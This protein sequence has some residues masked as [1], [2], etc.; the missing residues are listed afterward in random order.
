MNLRSLLLVVPA[1]SSAL[2]FADAPPITPLAAKSWLLLDH[3]SGQVLTAHDAETRIEPASLTKLMTAY[4]T[5]KSLKEGKI[6]LD[7][8]FTVSMKGYKVG[9]STMFLEPDRPASVDDLIKG[10]IVV[11]GNDAC[12]T[13][14][15]AVAGSEEI[16][17]QM[18][19][20]EAKRLGMANTSFRNS[21]GMPD[22]EHYTT[23][24]DL[25]K[26]AA[27]II[28]DFPQFYPI[29][30]MKDFTYS[31][32]RKT[33]KQPNRNLL[34]YRDAFVDGLKT[35][36]TASAGYN[37]IASTKR[38]NRRLI[39]VVVGTG[40]EEA[41]AKES[42]RLLGWGIQ[43]FD[44]PKIA[45]AGQSLATPR[46]WKGAADQVQAGFLQDQHVTVGKG[47]AAGLKQELLFSE[48]LIAPI[49]QGQIIGKMK[50]SLNGK[51]LAEYPVVALQSVEQGGFFRRLID[52]IRLWFR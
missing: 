44:A 15:E 28:R 38:D 25:A 49:Q 18:M 46:V 39:S 17:A 10:M 29:Y 51:P 47:E 50:V 21:S 14:A 42:A 30:S 26:L 45:S 12:V 32:G 5:F 20:A 33:I 37:L 9:G 16:F 35:G 52:A 11:S 48:P 41:R 23:A 34:L 36:H 4:L 3:Q 6:K 19:T 43:F 7:Q 31:N 13:L 2:V 22:P 1:L 8:Q 24:A 27:A 40:G